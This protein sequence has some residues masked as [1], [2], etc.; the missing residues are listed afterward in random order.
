MTAL[1]EDL[2]QRERVTALG[3]N[4]ELEIARMTAFG[5]GSMQR[6]RPSCL[7]ARR[8]LSYVEWGLSPTQACFIAS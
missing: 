6:E 4:S 8:S 3:E 1:G 7:V 5:G 2:I